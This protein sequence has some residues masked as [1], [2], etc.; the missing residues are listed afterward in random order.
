MNTHHFTP[1]FCSFFKNL[2]QNNSSIWFHANKVSYEKEV[3]KPFEVFI[4]AVVQMIQKYDAGVTMQAKD[5]IFR[6]NRDTRF[7]A[8]KSPYKTTMS[9]AISGGGKNPAYPGL[10]LEFSHTGITLMGGV[11]RV[12]KENLLKLRRSMVANLK[13]FQKLVNDKRFVSHYGKIE[14]TKHTLLAGEFKAISKTEPLI[15]KKEF[16][17]RAHLP[18]S[19]ITDAKLLKTIEEY[20]LVA[21]PVNEFLITGLFS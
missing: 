6:I 2:S 17:F 8:D 16:Y 11:Y 14:G 13:T 20:Y 9:A 19:L 12:D 7:Q 5:A 21:K 3:K 1:G 15:C 4:A 10:H 18:A